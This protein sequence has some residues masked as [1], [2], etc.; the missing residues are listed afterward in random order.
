MPGIVLGAKST[1]GGQDSMVPITHHKV[2]ILAGQLRAS[3]MVLV[4]KNPLATADLRDSG[5]IPG[6]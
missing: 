4:V 2:Y 1:A 6:P 3:Q 5:S